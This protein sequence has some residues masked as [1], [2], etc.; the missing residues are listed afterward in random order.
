MSKG[1]EYNNNKINNDNINQNKKIIST[2]IKII[3]TMK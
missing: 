2:I 3:I 1:K